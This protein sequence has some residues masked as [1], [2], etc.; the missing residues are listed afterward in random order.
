[1]GRVDNL[2]LRKPGGAKALAAEYDKHRPK[3]AR[4][5]PWRVI[6]GALKLF[7]GKKAKPEAV[8]KATSGARR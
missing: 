1:M 6:L 2:K 3:D 5:E 7:Q 8:P 4:G